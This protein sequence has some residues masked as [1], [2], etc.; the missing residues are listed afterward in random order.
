[1]TAKPAVWIVEWKF[2]SEDWRPIWTIGVHSTKQNSERDK[3]IQIKENSS[4]YVKPKYR[5][6]RYIREESK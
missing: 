4:L 3:R 2:P 1:M 6:R 5:V